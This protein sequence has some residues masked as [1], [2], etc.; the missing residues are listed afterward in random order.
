MRKA[1][2]DKGSRLRGKTV[3]E[4]ANLA[5]EGDTAAETALKIIKQAKRKGEHY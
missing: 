4:I 3:G 5:A 2:G 1:L